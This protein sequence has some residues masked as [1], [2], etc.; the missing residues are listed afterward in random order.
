MK[1]ISAICENKEFSYKVEKRKSQ[2]AEFHQ[3][4]FYPRI[5]DKSVQQDAEDEKSIFRTMN[6]SVGGIGLCSTVPLQNGDVINILLKIGENPSFECMCLIRWI[7]FN[8]KSCIAGC[9]F[10][11]LTLNQIKIIEQY[12]KGRHKAHSNK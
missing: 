11:M 6:I 5:N 4:I 10:I 8:D 2:R 7:G 3:D 9:E 1:S 12:V